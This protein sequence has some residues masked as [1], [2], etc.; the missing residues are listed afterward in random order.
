[1]ILPVAELTMRER[2]MAE[3]K[4][5]IAVAELQHETVLAK[6]T[7]VSRLEPG[8]MLNPE[9]EITVAE[10]PRLEL[11]GMSEL[12]RETTAVEVSEVPRLEPTMLS[13]H[14]TVVELEAMVSQ[15]QLR[16][17]LP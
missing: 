7:E 3:S 10:L 2:H 6:V 17:S 1:M 4:H 13:K 9:C 5:D 14:A 12:E 16:P 11:W 15:V 8:G